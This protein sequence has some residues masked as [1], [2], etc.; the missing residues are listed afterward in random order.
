MRANV[1][2]PYYQMRPGQFV[3]AR[4]VTNG[5]QR[6]V[7]V[8]PRSAVLQVEGEPSVFVSLGDGKYVARPVELGQE[9]Q[10]R[11]EIERGLLEGDVVV[12]EGAFVLK[13]ELL[14]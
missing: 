10:N 11:I 1:D 8:V 14:R 5:D 3:T 12:T 13:S 7:L 9:A 6:T 2:A 4:L